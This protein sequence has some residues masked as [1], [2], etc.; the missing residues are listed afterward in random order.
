MSNISRTDWSR[1]DA[2]TDDDIDTSDSPPLT[3]TFFSKAKLRVPDTSLTTVAIQVDSDT[4]AWFQSKG[5]AA[6]QHMAAALRI[7]AEAQKNVI[8]SIQVS[9]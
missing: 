5:E 8:S 4:L 7:Y 9:S 1:I 2:M 6:Q 3:E